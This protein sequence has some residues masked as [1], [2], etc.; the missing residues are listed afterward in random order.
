MHTTNIQ[1]LSDQLEQTTCPQYVI[2]GAKHPSQELFNLCVQKKLQERY[3][4]VAEN[5]T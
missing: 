3:T 4:I 5:I 1:Q 2:S